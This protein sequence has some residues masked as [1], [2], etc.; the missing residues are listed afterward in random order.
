MSPP[1]HLTVFEYE[2]CGLSRCVT[3]GRGEEGEKRKKRGLYFLYDLEYESLL[4]QAVVVQS[5]FYHDVT[6]DLRWNGQQ[7]PY[8]SPE[9]SA[10]VDR[11]L[12]HKILY[13]AIGDYVC[14]PSHIHV[15]IAV[16]VVVSTRYNKNSSP[17]RD[18]G[19]LLAY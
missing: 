3:G 15:L 10:S 11:I 13:V 9:Y 12:Q 14:F 1:C 7:Q 2:F 19:N 18:R 5:A 6:P 16:V 4:E 17:P 8:S